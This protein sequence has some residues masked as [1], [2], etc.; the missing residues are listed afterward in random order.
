MG[1]THTGAQPPSTCHLP[2]QAGTL[3][4]FTDN[5]TE[6]RAVS[7]LVGGMPL[8]APGQAGACS[9]TALAAARFGFN[10]SSS[11]SV[12]LDADELESFCK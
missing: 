6:K 10:T 4:T 5:T 9:P 1:A 12:S 3:A 8:P 7:R 11:C 2:S